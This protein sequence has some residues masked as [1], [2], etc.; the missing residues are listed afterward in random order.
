MKFVPVIASVTVCPDTADVGATLAIVGAG[1]TTEKAP[2]SIAVPPPKPLFVIVT[3]LEP[4]VAP[5]AT[6]MFTVI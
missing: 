1:F 3:S 6:V 4:I 2:G 5:S